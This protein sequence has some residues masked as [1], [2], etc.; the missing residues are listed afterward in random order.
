VV[1]YNVTCN[2]PEDL[3]EDWLRWMREEHLPEVMST[4]MFESYAMHRLLTEVDDNSGINFTIIYRCR[5]MD[6]YEEYSQKHGP[7]LKAKTNARYGDS[8]LAFRTLMEEI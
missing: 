4:G 6:H 5:S 1:L 8:V 7:A 3:A 2:V